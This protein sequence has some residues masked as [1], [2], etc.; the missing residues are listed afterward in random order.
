MYIEVQ[1]YMCGPSQAI[2]LANQLLAHRLSIYGYHQT[3]FTPGLWHDVMRP[4]NITLV[5]DYFGVQYVGS[6]M[7]WK[8]TT[9]FQKIG[10]VASTVALL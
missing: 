7:L 1:K 10:L 2:I 9:Q 4:I 3:K 5:V 6:L 8:R